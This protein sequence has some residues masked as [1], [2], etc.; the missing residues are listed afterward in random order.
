MHTFEKLFRVFIQ[1]IDYIRMEVFM[2]ILVL[3]FAPSFE[4]KAHSQN[5]NVKDQLT[6]YGV[7]FLHLPSL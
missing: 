4:R 2:K 7:C 5:E 6:P 3:F 1:K